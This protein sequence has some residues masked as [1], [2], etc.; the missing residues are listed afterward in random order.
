M[1]AMAE[2]QL[3]EHGRRRAPLPGGDRALRTERIP[4]MVGAVPAALR[5]D[6]PSRNSGGS[7]PASNSA[8]PTRSVGCGMNGFADRAARELGATGETVRVRRPERDRPADRPRAERRSA[9][10]R[11][12]HQSGHR[13]ATV[14]Q[15]PHRRV[16]PPQGL[17]EARDQLTSGAEDGADASRGVIRR[18]ARL[19]TY[20]RV[21]EGGRSAEYNRLVRS[22]RPVYRSQHCRT[23]DWRPMTDT[24]PEGPA[25]CCS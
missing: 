12:P 22:A 6:A 5:G 18:A 14:H 15:R 10:S 13:R 4:I 1:L 2:A 24:S 19:V 16:P 17:H 25:A 21:P 9:R 8:R 20:T 23:T 11:G 3:R 7:M